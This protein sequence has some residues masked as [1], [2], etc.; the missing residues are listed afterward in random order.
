MEAQAQAKE[1]EGR[2]SESTTMSWE[3]KD[4]AATISS[5]SGQQRLSN[6]MPGKLSECSQWLEV[7]SQIGAVNTMS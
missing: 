3:K 1:S 6:W 5:P 4:M 2:G 7:K